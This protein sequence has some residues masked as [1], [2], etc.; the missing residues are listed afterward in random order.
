MGG[1]Q[2]P[3]M[4]A[5]IS[6]EIPIMGP[7]VGAAVTPLDL[8]RFQSKAFRFALEQKRQQE[9]KDVSTP[10]QEALREFPKESPLQ[11]DTPSH[12]LRRDHLFRP[13]FNVKVRATSVQSVRCC[14]SLSVSAILNY[15]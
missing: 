3:A 15:F 9:E 10:R 8:G 7:Q 6:P 11:L 1:S 4:P 14:Y 5:V 13:S 12:F 2:K